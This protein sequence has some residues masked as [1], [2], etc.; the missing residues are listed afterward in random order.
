MTTKSPGS[1]AG[2]FDL[3][4]KVA[5]VTGG[6]RGLGREMALAFARAGSDVIVASRKMESCIATANEIEALGRRV[7]AYACHV[8]DWNALDALV[9]T[10]YDR[11]GKVDV[12]VNN[13]GMSPLYPSLDQ[14][15]EALWD[16]V[17]AV[18]LKG[19]FR[20]SA[21]VGAR[22]QA[23]DGGSIINISSMAAERP[24][25]TETPY[26]AAKA[27][28][29]ALTIA[30]SQAWGPKVRVNAIQAGPFLTDISKA[31]PPEVEDYLAARASLARAGRPDE[32]VG[33]ALY[34]ASAASSFTTGAI[35]RVDGGQK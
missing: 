32:I 9:D 14:V 19:P 34:L 33:T 12:L 24:T 13:A 22:M 2:L 16:K 1:V 21:L 35:L 5:L 10:A 30:C 7:L 25:P 31:W 15:S 28:L 20:L 17:L 23:G 18:N 8:G 29:N 11:F 6:S 26:A 4:G 3:T 27:G